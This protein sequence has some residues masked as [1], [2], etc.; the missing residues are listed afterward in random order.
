[1]I[2][3]IPLL[4]GFINPAVVKYQKN[5]QF[6]KE[7]Y[8]RLSIFLFDTIVVLFLA[9]LTRSAASLIWG[10]IGGAVFEVLFSLFFIK[11]A[12]RFKIEAEKIKDIVSRG[13]WITL[14]GLFNYLFEHGD[15]IA[16]GRLLNT[17][18]LGTYQVAYRI[19]SIPITEIGVIFNQVTFPIFT[20]IADKDRLKTALIK[21]TLVVSLIVIPFGLILYYYPKE[22]IVIVL[23]ENWLEAAA[24]IKILAF[25][26]VYRAITTVPHNVFLALKKQ[27]YVTY[28]HFAGIVGL[29]VLIIPLVNKYGIVGAGFSAMIGAFA[30]SLVTVYYTIKIFKYNVKTV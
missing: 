18:L 27:K 1:M 17:T 14:Y 26:G 22:V 19:T 10:L 20:K 8:L 13:K 30:S 4:K 11:P 24:V 12:P 28:S 9:F 16:V 6:N 5:L 15:D 3:V 2:S 25:F 29:A 7:F 23:G 21:I